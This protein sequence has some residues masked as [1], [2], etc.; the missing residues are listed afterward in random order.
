MKFC[1]ETFPNIR[2]MKL[3][4]VNEVACNH[5]LVERK[6]IDRTKENLKKMKLDFNRIDG[7]LGQTEIKRK[8]EHLEE[9]PFDWPSQSQSQP[10]AEGKLGGYCHGTAE[11]L[12]RGRCHMTTSMVA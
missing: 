6:T 12:L 1:L 9:S 3:D 2:T 5:G 4:R 11:R 7:K 10:Q 8:R